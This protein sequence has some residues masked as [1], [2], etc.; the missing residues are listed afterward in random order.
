MHRRRRVA[1]CP[2]GRREKQIADRVRWLHRSD[3]AELCETR[4]VLRGENLCVLDAPARF[5]NLSLVR[6]NGLERF[7][8]KIEDH[9]IRAI[10]D[11]VRFDLNA[12]AQ[13]FL[14]HRR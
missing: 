1:P 3:D 11:G 6:R 2:D 7:F 13:R 10:A 14:E 8:V 4:K 12:A 9:S 5:A